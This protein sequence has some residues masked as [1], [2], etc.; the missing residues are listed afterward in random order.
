MNKLSFCQ[1]IDSVHWSAEHSPSICSNKCI[2]DM[3]ISFALSILFDVW[4]NISSI[5][6]AAVNRSAHFTDSILDTLR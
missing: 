5:L 3:A 6:I 1:Q 4:L 2:S